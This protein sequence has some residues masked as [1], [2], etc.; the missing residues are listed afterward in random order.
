M[1]YYDLRIDGKT[2]CSQSLTN[3][4]GL[5][6]QFNIQTY[7]EGKNANSEITIYNP[8]LWMF[9]EYM[10]LYNKKVELYAGVSNT[11]QTKI[12]GISPPTQD[13]LMVGFVSTILPQ[14]NEAD[15]QLTLVMTQSPVYATNADGTVD[16]AT[17]PGGY[18]FRL[19]GREDA[20]KAVE[21]ALAAVSPGVPV[22]AIGTGLSVPVP[23]QAIVFSAGDVASIVSTWG[24]VLQCGSEG[25]VLKERAS[26]AYGQEVK[27]KKQDFLCQPSPLGVS[28]MAITSYLRG[29]IR[30]GD[31]IVMPDDVFIG[32]SNLSG[33][34]TNSSG[35]D[36]FL[37]SRSKNMFTMF[38][39]SWSVT[40][41]WHVGDVRNNDPQ[42]WA[43]HFEVARV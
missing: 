35:V 24:Y 26:A 16:A 32:V 39:G 2:L 5:N 34:I 41:I 6:L 20:L 10:N 29:D 43:T 9:G 23:C 3:P 28:T 22:S 4:T 7:N 27:L 38:S 21:D 1:R 33:V 36:A 30:M 42:S 19:K 25:Y 12:I 17:V 14:W 8:P 13:L 40:K 18:Q 11:P 31:R 37:D 15:M